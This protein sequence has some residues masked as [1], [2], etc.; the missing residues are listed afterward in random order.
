M[1][2]I[3]VSSCENKSCYYEI[4]FMTVSFALF[5]VSELQDLPPSCNLRGLDTS[6]M[7]AAKF[8]VRLVQGR[9]CE[10]RNLVTE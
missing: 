4:T 2:I 1:D 5:M 7:A 9:S 8:P 3:L 10:L 6:Q